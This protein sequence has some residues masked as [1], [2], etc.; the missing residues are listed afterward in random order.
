MFRKNETDGKFLF[1]F[2][3]CNKLFFVLHFIR[4]L[5]KQV[6]LT[7]KNWCYIFDPYY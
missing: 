2:C 6:A 4:L 1:I 7:E 5:G 3:S